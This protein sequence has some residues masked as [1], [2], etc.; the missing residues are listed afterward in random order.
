MGRL[1]VFMK[2]KENIEFVLDY[3]ENNLKNKIT[4]EK[5]AD[6]AGYSKYHFLRIFNEAVKLTPGRLYTQAEIIRNSA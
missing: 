6:I 4:I 3:I 1:I 5:L 2:Y